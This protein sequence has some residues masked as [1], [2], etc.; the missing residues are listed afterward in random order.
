MDKCWLS[1][2]LEARDCV[3]L[4]TSLDGFVRVVL[5]EPRYVLFST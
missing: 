2:W 5:R 4:K 1:A 3:A